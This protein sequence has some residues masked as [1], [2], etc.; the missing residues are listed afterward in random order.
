[1]AD[2]P[3]GR[4]FGVVLCGLALLDASAQEPTLTVQNLAPFPRR[5][6]V[7]VVVPFAAGRWPE[8]PELQ[9]AGTPT[10]WQPFGARWPDGS[11]RQALCLFTAEVGALR[12]QRYELVPAAGTAAP[13]AGEVVMPTCELTVVVRVDGSESRAVPVRVGDLE[14][15][16]A[17]RV[18]LRR[19]RVG[20]S[21]IVAELVVTA[22]RD[23]PVAWLDVGVFWSD[24]TRPAMQCQ[25]DELA[26][27]ARGMALVLRHPGR[28][29]VQQTTTEHGS[30]CVLLQRR[31]LG[32]GQGLRRTGALVPP[33]RAD[34]SLA[35]E[36]SKAA[37][38][39]PL[40]GATDWRGSGAFGAFGHVP[41]HPQW[42]SGGPLREHLAAR[43]RAFVAGD[44]PGGDPLGAPV[45]GL[46]MSAGQTGDQE[47]FGV[48]KLS[49]VAASGLPSLLLEAEAS[50]LQEGCRPVHVFE[51]DGRPV[52]PADHPRWVVWS[53]RTHWHGEVS[54]DRLGKPHPEPR[55]ET[56][57]WSGKDREHWS[58]NNLG[59]FALLTGAH[60][61]RLELQNEIRLYLAGQTVDPALT[62]SGVG[63]PRGAGRVALAAAW[64]WL[65]TG[66]DALRRRIDERIDRV[67]HP[68]WVGRT[69]AADAV[70]PLGVATPDARML[71]GKVDY[72]TPWQ[73]ALAAVGFAATHRITGNPRARE[74][75]E[76]IAT[77]VVRHGWLLSERECIV[78]T[79]MRWQSGRPL[80]AAEL[81]GGDP[82]AVLWSHGTAFS[83]WSLGAVAIARAAAEANG[84]HALAERAAAIQARCRAA[85]RVRSP[86]ALRWIEWDA[87]VWP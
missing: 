77:T 15:N 1:M 14:A 13:A 61:A 40:L 72:W 58:S 71:Q 65:A 48:V 39:A 11:V 81:A 49:L 28:L 7:A 53:G 45:L 29:G 33:L 54:P 10:V 85:Q 47:D 78:A 24:P 9:V 16:A 19:A 82:T 27:E 62:T 51:A 46:A 43:H 56:S 30:R 63:A 60:W 79:A 42:L 21:G 80:S 52:D 31:V 70:R 25:V 66:D 18:E 55:F 3:V 59:A 64:Q 4:H 76:T 20:A 50:L 75:A 41:E 38:V 83:E 17:R 22:W 2:A 5:E 86:A 8:L 37:C 34:R 84:D 87:V 23:Q 69:L 12:E 68:G 57:G 32:D 6:G 35:D 36:T 44:T 26:V 73:E 67:Y 74:L